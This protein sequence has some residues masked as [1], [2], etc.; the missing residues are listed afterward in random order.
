MNPSIIS[1]IN[2]MIA[3]IIFGRQNQNRTNETNIPMSSPVHRA[4]I[5]NFFP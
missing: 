5:G 3:L 1:G 2:R 4:Q